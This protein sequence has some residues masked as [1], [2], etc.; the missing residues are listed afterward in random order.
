[1]TIHILL[2]ILETDILLYWKFSSH[3]QNKKD[4]IKSPHFLFVNH[5]KSVSYKFDWI[6]IIIWFNTKLILINKCIIPYTMKSQYVHAIFLIKILWMIFYLCNIVSFHLLNHY[7]INFDIPRES[8][9]LDIDISYGRQNWW[10]KAS[11]CLHVATM[12]EKRRG[13][14]LYVM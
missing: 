11:K 6:R 3:W 9:I 2:S 7:Q 1:M 5:Y 8:S 10:L 12:D 13:S 14:Y 4:S